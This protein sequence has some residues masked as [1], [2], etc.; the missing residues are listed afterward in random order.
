MNINIISFNIRCANDKNGNSIPERAPRLFSAT[1]PYNADVIG[2]QECTDVWLPLIEKGLGNDYEIFNKWRSVSNCESC[3][4]LWKKDKFDCIDKGYFWL[5]DTPDEE[6]NGWDEIGCY[7]ICMHVTLKSKETGEEFTHLNT[8]FGFGDACQTA[9]AELILKRITESGRKNIF[10][11][12]D[13][14]MKPDSPGYAKMTESLCDVNEATVKDRAPTFHG[15]DRSGWG[16]HI[17]YCFAD[18]QSE[19]KAFEIITAMPNGQFPS[20]HYGIFASVK[21][22]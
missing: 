15:Y 5:S 14:N 16:E 9:S 18:K 1:A 3:P 19:P 8:H 13:F 2:F 10:I 7:R 6:S 20:D 21:I 17:D 11:T 22:K 4:I 12:G